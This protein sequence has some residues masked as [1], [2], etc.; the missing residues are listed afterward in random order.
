MSANLSANINGKRKPILKE[1]PILNFPQHSCVSFLSKPRKA[2]GGLV[3][4]VT[5]ANKQTTAIQTAFPLGKDIVILLLGKCLRFYNVNSHIFY[6]SSICF[7]G[8]CVSV[9]ECACVRVHACVC[10]CVCACMHMCVCVC[11]RVHA[12]VCECVCVCV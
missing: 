12:R 2:C 9:C 5:Q 8:Q 11:V 10:V 4:T 1:K 3:S 7:F 6:Y